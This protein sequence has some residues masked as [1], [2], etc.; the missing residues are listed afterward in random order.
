MQTLTYDKS[1]ENYD[2]RELARRADFAA[3]YLCDKI[4]NIIA[5]GV[6]AYAKSCTFKTPVV[7]RQ[8]DHSFQV[9]GDMVLDD[10]LSFHYTATVGVANTD[11][12]IR[13]VADD[14]QHSVIVA[15]LNTL[16]VSQAISNLLNRLC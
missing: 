3:D 10:S 7:T 14:T 16:G 11:D 8:P 4:F 2:P 13:I 1:P 5:L 6:S 9:F 12:S 15:P